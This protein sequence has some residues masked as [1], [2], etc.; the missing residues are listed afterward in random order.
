MS[1]ILHEKEYPIDP[2]PGSGASSCSLTS[3]L[4]G[5]IVRFQPHTNCRKVIENIIEEAFN[6]R[7]ISDLSPFSREYP[8]FVKANTNDRSSER[9]ED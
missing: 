8:D 7:L 1:N 9:S 4:L 3:I 2:T 5:Q 6:A